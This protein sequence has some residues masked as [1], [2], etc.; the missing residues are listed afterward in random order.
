[1]NA[2]QKTLP[3]GGASSGQVNAEQRLKELRIELPAPPS[4]FSAVVRWNGQF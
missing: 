2:N 4:E 1:M 3:T